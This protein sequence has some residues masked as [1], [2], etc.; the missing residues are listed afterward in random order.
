MEDISKTWKDEYWAI[1]LGLLLL[2]TMIAPDHAM[3]VMWVL[4]ATPVWIQ[5]LI[6]GV[7]SASYGGNIWQRIS[8]TA[9]PTATKLK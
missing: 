3:R 4:Q 8:T 7:V 5:W 9:K 1:V 6:A 2:V